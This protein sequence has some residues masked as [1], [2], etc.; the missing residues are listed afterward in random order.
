MAPFCIIP[1]SLNPLAVKLKK[2]H[3]EPSDIWTIALYTAICVS[4][5]RHPFHFV[6]PPPPINH[7]SVGKKKQ[8]GWGGGGGGGKVKGLKDA[9]EANCCVQCYRSNIL[10]FVVNFFNLTARGLRETGMMQKGAIPNKTGFT[11]C[12]YCR[13]VWI[14]FHK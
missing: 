12:G 13:V 14:L 11:Y 1:V 6:P 3:N 10:R 2:I 5:I 7:K 4:G 8:W 9:A